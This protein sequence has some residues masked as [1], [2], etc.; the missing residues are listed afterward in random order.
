MKPNQK[1][2]YLNRGSSHT[3]GC[4][5]AIVK[6]VTHLLTALTTVTASN[7]DMQLQHL[8]PEHF[9]AMA[10]AHLGE[11]TD[12][13]G[14]TLS[15]HSYN[16][17]L[18]DH[19]SLCANK[20]KKRRE[21]D[22]K[23]AI[24]FKIAF[25]E[26]WKQPIHKMIQK[27]KKRFPLLSWIRVSVSYTRFTN[28]REC[29]QGDLNSQLLDSVRSLDFETL[30]CNCKNK[31]ACPYR[32]KCRT[33]IVVY[34]ATCLTTGKKYIGNTQQ[35]VKT[36]IQ[37][38]IGDTK[39][40]L[41]RA[42]KSD[43]F[44]EHFAR[45]IPENVPRKSANRFLP[46]SN[47]ILWKGNPLNCVKTFS[48]GSCKLCSKERLAILKL[49]RLSPFV[50]SDIDAICGTDES[51]LDERVSQGRDSPSSL[52]ET[53]EPDTVDT[54]SPLWS[55]YGYKVN[56]RNGLIAR[57]QLL[58]DDVEEIDDGD[59]GDKITFAD[60]TTDVQPADPESWDETSR[61]GESDLEC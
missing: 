55:P 20:L 21:K 37:Q 15:E 28:L 59:D 12:I 36:R 34:Q 1:L 51:S 61:V 31:V 16:M 50:K 44:A 58:K 35:K 41:Y 24:W 38:H 22:R 19:E 17:R 60:G 53:R 18:E 54:P 49:T 23:R 26:S 52:E 13:G 4:L 32:G 2:K 45:L 7:K 40:L 43:S 48:T 29:F 10:V 5:K 47:D 33:S 11:G 30:D 27:V 46:M 9:S 25:C 14:E 56:R 8:Y 3:P 6:G 42:K 57:A 39:N